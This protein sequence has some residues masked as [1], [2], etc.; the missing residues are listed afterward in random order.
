MPGLR[1]AQS[2]RS[3]ALSLLEA[4]R[5]QKDSVAA[6][7]SVG[8]QGHDRVEAGSAQG[9]VNAKKQAD[10]GTHD[11]AH[12]RHPGAHGGWKGRKGAQQEGYEESKSDAQDSAGQALQQ[13]FQNELAQNVALR[14]ADRPAHADFAFA[15]RNADEDEDSK[16]RAAD[17]APKGHVAF[18]GADKEVVFHLAAEM[19][20]GA[21]DQ[22]RLILRCFERPLARF[23]IDGEARMDA[24]NTEEDRERD[25]D[26]VILVLAENAANLF[27]D[28]NDHELVVADANAPADRINSEEKLLY[29]RIADQADVGTVFGLGRTEITAQL[30]GARVDIGHAWRLAVKADVLGLFVGITR[31]H[32]GAGGGADFRA[33]RTALGDRAYVFRL[34][35]LVLERLDDDAEVGDGERRAGDLE[36]VGS[37]IGDLVFD[38][39]V[40]T[41]HDGHYGDQ[42]GHAH[43]QA[44]HGERGA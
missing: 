15:Q 35:F 21:Q 1:P 38:I 34:D 26:K 4:K 13:A 43:G 27:H 17:A 11:Q 44:E 22:L 42:S 40:G 33:R 24:L 20:A 18:L 25:R 14:R 23:D 37:E 5:V 12:D 32:G 6:G 41:L 2:C 19:A 31:P 28:A 30:H 10:G 29:Q 7:S 39:E 8:P 16:K 36:D 3:C 9:R